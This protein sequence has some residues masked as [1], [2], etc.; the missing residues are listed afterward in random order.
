MCRSVPQIDAVRTRTS[1]SAGPID[2]TGAFSNERPRAGCI[3][4][5]AFIIE[6]IQ[7]GSSQPIAMVAHAHRTDAASLHALAR[8]DVNPQVF[9]HLRAVGRPTSPVPQRRSSP[10]PADI[11]SPFPPT[12]ALTPP[13]RPPEFSAHSDSHARHSA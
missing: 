6:D 13:H 5:K 2:G 3:L 12:P 4:R 10:T 9:K 7:S 11:P 8:H 1:T